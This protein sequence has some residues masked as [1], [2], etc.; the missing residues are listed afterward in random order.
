MAGLYIHVPFCRSKCA[1]CDFYS[2]PRI[3][4]FGERFVEAVSEEWDHRKGEINEIETIYIG[5]GTPSMLDISQFSRLISFIP[6]SGDIKEFTIEVNPEDVSIEKLEAWSSLGVNRISMGVQSFNDFELSFVG[7]SHNSWKAVEAYELIK[8]YIQNISIDL[9]IALP[10]QTLESLHKNLDMTLALSPAHVSVYILGYEKGTRLWAM[11]KSGKLQSTDDETIEKMYQLVCS[12]LKEGGYDHYEISNF[13][14]PGSR[15]LHNSNYWKGKPYLGLGPGAH[16]LD[17]SGLRRVN[18]PNI[19]LWLERIEQNERAYIED[20]ETD[21]EKIND[22]IMIRLRT[23]EGL[24]L[25]DIP[26]V[27]L[28][29]LKKNVKSLAPGDVAFD[30]N[31]LIIPEQKWIVSDGIISSL[32]LE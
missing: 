22:L 32:F 16:S 26:P 9:I 31:H 4:E 27:Y 14:L 18:P 28:V 11:L 24:S 20:K 2:L 23:K 7:R 10:G 6:Y 12:K 19:K 3:K 21:I 17:S 8:D 30:G 29:T 15:A 25:S 1:Y 5:G 13:A